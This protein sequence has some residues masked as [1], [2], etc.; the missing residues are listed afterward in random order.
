MKARKVVIFALLAIL[1]LS[2]LACGGGGEGEDEGGVNEVK[3]GIGAPLIGVFGAVI[4]IATQQGFELA[5]DYIGEFTVAGQSY[6]WDLI[7]E[8]SGIGAEGGVASATKL[9]FEDDVKIMTQ[10]YGDPGLAA[11]TICEQSGVILFTSA[12]PLEAFG[13]DKPHTFL[14]VTPSELPAATLMKYISEAY[15]EVETASAITW[16]T[17]TGRIL[18]EAVAEA[19]EYYGIEWLE[20]EYYPPGTTEFYPIA[21]KMA[22]KNPDLCYVNFGSLLPLHEMGWDGITFYSLWYTAYGEQ[23]GWDNIQGHLSQYPEPY[24]EDLPELVKEMAAEYQQRH[25]VEFSLMPF[26]YAIQ[27]YYLTAALEKAGT[28]DDVDQIIATLETETFDTP[29]G[30]VWFGFEELYGIGHTLVMPCWVGEIRDRE[31]QRVFE[32]ST[33]EADA[34]TLEIFGK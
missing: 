1:L 12:L 28:V 8:D 25:N 19:A 13:P 34:L 29:I 11:Q 33:D 3:L 27:L 15:P 6:K 32:V 16:D 17:V 18:T 14:G 20:T 30:P 21:A 10:V 23:V 4:G 26:Y 24:G 31:Y 7:F 22:S 2:T 5:N 9:I